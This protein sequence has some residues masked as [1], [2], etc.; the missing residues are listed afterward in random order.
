MEGNVFSLRRLAYKSVS[1]ETKLS[2]YRVHTVVSALGK[3]TAQ[4]IVRTQVQYRPCRPPRHDSLFLPTSL[5]Y[6][7]SSTLL[8]LLCVLQSRKIKTIDLKHRG[9][10]DKHPQ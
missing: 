4:H 9:E 8:F 1:Q 6:I 5:I 7:C 10:T 2:W 3:L